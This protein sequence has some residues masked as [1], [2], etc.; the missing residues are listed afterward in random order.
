MDLV[1]P[2]T[3]GLQIRER[4]QNVARIFCEPATF[5]NVR[6]REKPAFAQRFQ[7]HEFSS[8][9]VELLPQTHIEASRKRRNLAYVLYGVSDSDHD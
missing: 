9:L 2:F 7:L 4:R 8:E 3:V 5:L 1:E 6:F